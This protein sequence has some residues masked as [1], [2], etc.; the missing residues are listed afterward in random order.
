MLLLI[1]LLPAAGPRAAAQPVSRFLRTHYHAADGTWVRR[2][3]VY[4]RG[5]RTDIPTATCRD[6]AL[7][8]AHS[9]IGQCSHH[10]GI[11]P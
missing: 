6:G 11:A 9:R 1:A 2:P 3:R 8:F 7:S 5:P 10:G 4:K